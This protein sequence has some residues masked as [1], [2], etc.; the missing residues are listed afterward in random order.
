MRICD[1]KAFVEVAD[2]GSF[3]KAAEKLHISQ[4][5]LSRRISKLEYDLDSTLLIRTN[6]SVE[7]TDSGKEFL[8][9]AR[10]LLAIEESARRKIHA[11]ENQTQKSLKV[12]AI[13]SIVVSVLPDVF[14]E[15]NRKH[16]DMAVSITDGNMDVLNDALENG[17]A[18]F[19]VGMKYPSQ[20]NFTSF[21]FTKERLGISFSST[22]PLAKKKK[23]T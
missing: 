22:H 4:P 2:L 17:S 18:D 20:Q 23:V 15:L 19:I 8:L 16:S 3:V 6:R 10:K 5:A 14:S 12:A 21:G 9:S 13:P 11:I 1:L 7:I